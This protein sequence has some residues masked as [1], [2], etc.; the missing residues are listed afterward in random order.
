MYFDAAITCQ[1]IQAQHVPYAGAP[2]KDKPRVAVSAVL[3]KAY[4]AMKAT[5]N[6]SIHG[7]MA[8]RSVPNA[9]RRPL[10]Q[11]RS[12]PHHHPSLAA[13]VPY[14]GAPAKDKSRVVE[15][16]VLGKAYVAMLATRNLSIHGETA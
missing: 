12:E 2:A 6:L 13:H 7:E 14:A 11:R 16:A 8:S 15:S 9:H 10:S 1:T 3:G 5:R 4:V